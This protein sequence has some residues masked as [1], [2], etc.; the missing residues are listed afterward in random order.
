MTMNRNLTWM[1]QYS[2]TSH[3]AHSTKLDSVCKALD[4]LKIDL[5]DSINKKTETALAKTRTAWMMMNLTLPVKPP[6]PKP[7]PKLQFQLKLSKEWPSSSR[8]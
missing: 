5:R 8:S 2:E 7:K 1:K 4:D 3:H 6:Q